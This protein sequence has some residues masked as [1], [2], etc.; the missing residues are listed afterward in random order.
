MVGKLENILF[1]QKS[2]QV[3]N[4][5]AAKSNSH[6]LRKRPVREIMDDI[7]EMDNH[8]DKCKVKMN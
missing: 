1:E 3:S 4:I 7:T 6:L 2:R 5:Y 8:I